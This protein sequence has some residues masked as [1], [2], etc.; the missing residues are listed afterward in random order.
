MLLRLHAASLNFLDIAVAKGAIPIPSFPIISGHRRCP[1]KLSRSAE[2]SPAGRSEIVSCRISCRTGLNGLQQPALVDPRRG[3][4]LP[5]SLAEYVAVPATSLVRIPDYLTYTEAATLPIAATTAWRGVRSA[6]LGP[7]STALL[8]GTGGVSLFALQFAKAHG[9]RVI[10]T[11]SSDEKL[12]RARSMGA[13]ET[14]NYRKTPEWQKEVLQLTGGRGVDL[15]LETGGSQTLQRSLEAAAM[16]GT[17]FVIGFL[18]GREASVDVLQ[19]MEKSLRVIGNTTGPVSALRS[20]VA[21]LEAHQLK[22][23]VDKVFSFEDARAA[24]AHLAEGG[25]HFGKV[26]LSN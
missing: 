26:A 12:D 18:T 10:I 5:G 2:R 15:V 14:I 13:D 4:T 21:A 17:V 20:A 25:A 23:V 1:A 19:L 11:S 8:L 9:A 22:P 6:S 24:Y 3:L 7:G 16:N